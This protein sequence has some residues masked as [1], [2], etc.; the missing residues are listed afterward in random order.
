MCL[1]MNYFVKRFWQEN[2]PLSPR[3][4][5]LG[6]EQTGFFYADI[7]R[8]SKAWYA[9]AGEK[10]KNKPFSVLQHMEGRVSPLAGKV[11][12]TQAA[13]YLKDK[14]RNALPVLLEL[15]REFNPLPGLAIND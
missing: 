5:A 7:A 13:L 2:I 14:T 6:K 4:R 1:A 15:M 8:L 12:K 9:G 3:W 11:L 10:E